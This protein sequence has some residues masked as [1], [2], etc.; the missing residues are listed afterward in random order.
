MRKKHGFMSLAG[1]V[2]VDKMM[3]VYSMIANEGQNNFKYTIKEQNQHK[4]IVQHKKVSEGAEQRARENFPNAEFPLVAIE[5]ELL[6]ILND[7][8]IAADMGL[9]LRVLEQKM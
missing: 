4:H 3:Y 8:A 1:I 2:R 7:E 9:L 6:T 5:Q